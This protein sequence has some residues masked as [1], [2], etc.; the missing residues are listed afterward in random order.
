MNT[1][2]AAA[3][4][5]RWG[6]RLQCS[7]QQLSAAASGVEENEMIGFE[8]KVLRLEQKLLRFE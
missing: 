6:K 4:T 8:N 2:R 7:A 1:A 3:A 5:M